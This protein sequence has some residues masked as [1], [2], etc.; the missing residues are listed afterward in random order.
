[1]KLWEIVG[2]TYN[3]TLVYRTHL[4]SDV[5]EERIKR[6]LQSL[7]ISSSGLAFLT[8]AALIT[9]D[10][11]HFRVRRSPGLQPSFSCRHAHITFKAT[12]IPFDLTMVRGAYPPPLPLGF[13]SYEHLAH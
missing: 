7:T 11:R 10:R 8:T 1:M 9:G 3:R 5:S 12:I 4:D 13:R 2:V 6:I